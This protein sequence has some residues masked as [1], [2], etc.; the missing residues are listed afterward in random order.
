MI[1][2]AF[3]SVDASRGV[4]AVEGEDRQ[5]F[6][7]GLIS[8][9]TKR[10]SAD[11]AAYS[12]LL[13][14]QG[15]FLH[16][17]MVVEQPDAERYLL[18]PEAV[19][20]ADLVKRLSMY[21]LRSKVKVADLSEDW[22]MVLFFGPG[23]LAKLGLASAGQAKA[24]GEGVV[25]ADPRLP[26]L[27]AR[28]FLPK[29]RAGAIAAE[30]GFAAASL[31]EYDRLRIRLGIP[32]GSRDLA[33]EKAIL[34]ENGFDE[35]AGI[36]WEKGCYMGQE[37]TARTRYRG[38]VRKRLL[39]VEID[40]PLPASGTPLMLGDIAAGEMRSGAEAGGLGLAMIRLEHLERAK[41]ESLTAGDSRLRPFV[42]E[43]MR[44]P[45]QVG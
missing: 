17:F 30:A 16:E 19:R 22:S 27:G 31:G 34:L 1:D 13:T 15:K 32:L 40:G 12:A 24:L 26:D 20:T 18:D 39:P 7:Q 14:P 36:D 2:K 5:T 23:T 3:F 35:L 21:R 44:L 33:P 41:S 37:L 4:I 10:V 25:F 43:W 45:E 38:L 28:A 11:R 6:L 29:S 9:D 42:P 8:N